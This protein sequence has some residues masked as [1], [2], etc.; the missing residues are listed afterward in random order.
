MHVI[1]FRTIAVQNEEESIILHSNRSKQN[2]PDSMH[3]ILFRTIA[4]QYDGFFFILLPKGRT[5]QN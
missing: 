2:H 4:V 3:V 5:S 1:L